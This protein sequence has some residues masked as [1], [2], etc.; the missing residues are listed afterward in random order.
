MRQKN[1]NSFSPFPTIKTHGHKQI[2][3]ETPKIKIEIKNFF[4]ENVMFSYEKEN[5]TLRDTILEAVK[6]GVDLSWAELSEAELSL[7]ELS[8]A[9]LSEA[10]KDFFKIL[11]MAEEEIP[12][13]R[14]KL[15]N[16]GVNG[17]CYEGECCCLVG[18]I[19]NARGCAFNAVE[20]LTPDSHRPAERW[21]LVIRKGDT[22]EN[23]PVCEITVGWIDE[24]LDTIAIS[25]IVP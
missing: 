11:S 24:Y 5:N 20:G 7:A 4:T 15:L 6:Q 23:N 9:D 19:A 18:T 12:T 8:E 13:L 16:G 25:H 14:D 1:R 17:S 21:F 3:M 2:K 22:P 10:K